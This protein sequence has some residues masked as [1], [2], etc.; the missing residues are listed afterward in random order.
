MKTPRLHNYEIVKRTMEFYSD[1]YLRKAEIAQLAGLQFEQ[2]SRIIKAAWKLGWLTRIETPIHNN[3]FGKGKLPVIKTIYKIKRTESWSGLMPL[4]H[5]V[6]KKDR[7]E[8]T[9]SSQKN[10]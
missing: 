4:Y 9:D 2:A 8:R 5:Q 3:C 6:L 1:R 10:A 7:E